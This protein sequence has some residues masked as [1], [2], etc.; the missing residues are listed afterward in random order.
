MSTGPGPRTQLILS[1]WRLRRE[2]RTFQC[3]HASVRAPPPWPKAELLRQTTKDLK[4]LCQQSRQLKIQQILDEA[5]TAAHKGLTAV[6]QVVRR[7]APKTQPKPV[8]FRDSRGD[9]LST[10]Q[11]AQALKDYFEF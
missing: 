10:Q 9:P 4:A 8:V 2:R 3:N 5:H 6:H 11:E 7:L 1:L